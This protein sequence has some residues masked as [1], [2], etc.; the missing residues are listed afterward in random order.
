MALG[1]MYVNHPL[2]ASIHVGQLAKCVYG[3]EAMQVMETTP[4]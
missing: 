2:D 1:G 4:L 3:L